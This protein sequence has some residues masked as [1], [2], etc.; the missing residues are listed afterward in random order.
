MRYSRYRLCFHEVEQWQVYQTFQ[1]M[2]GYY[3]SCLNFSATIVVILLGP[4]L[5]HGIYKFLVYPLRIAART[6]K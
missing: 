4:V 2:Q 6:H 3:A 5:Q 1:E